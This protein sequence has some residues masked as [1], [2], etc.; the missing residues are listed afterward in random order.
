MSRKLENEAGKPKAPK[1]TQ[2]VSGAD[3]PP[4]GTVGEDEIQAVDL[5]PRSNGENEWQD[6][7]SADKHRPA[8]EET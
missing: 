5:E 1:A 6:E 3:V 7:R 8:G 2:D 4:V